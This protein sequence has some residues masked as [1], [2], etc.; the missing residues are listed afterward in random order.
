VRANSAQV[1]IDIPDS[2][3]STGSQFYFVQL[4]LAKGGGVTVSKNFYWVPATLTTFD[5]PKTTYINTPVKQPEVM[6]EL[7]KLPTTTVDAK[8]EL[9]G[10]A[11]IVRVA[12]RSKVLAFQ[13]EA[14]VLDESGNLIPAVMWSD[15]YVELMPGESEVLSA[16]VPHSY[17]GH[18]LKVRLAGWN[19]APWEQNVSLITRPAAR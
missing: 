13:L 9:E 10:D 17:D 2:V 16:A 19:V 11:V 12:N 4:A 3:W 7:R 5:W 6:T 18:S 1:A 8:A 15:N 14:E